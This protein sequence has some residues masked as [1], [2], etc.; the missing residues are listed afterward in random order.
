M[1]PPLRA[2]GDKTA[3]SEWAAMAASSRGDRAG[4]PPPTREQWAAFAREWRGYVAALSGGDGG[5]GNP[6]SPDKVAAMTPDQLAALAAIKREA[7]AAR[8]ALL[9]KE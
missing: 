3:R 6:L 4:V 8:D 7:E 9:R 2:L 5:R 1:P